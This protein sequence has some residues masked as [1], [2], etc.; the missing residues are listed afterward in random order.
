[1][2]GSINNG[3]DSEATVKKDVKIGD[4]SKIDACQGIKVVYS[5]GKNTGYAR[6]AT[7]PSAV[8]Y[9]KV[10]VK[11]GCLYARY[12]GKFDRIK[13]PSIIT[14]S[15][16][17]LTNIELS[18]AAN[19]NVI[20]DIDQNEA[21]DIDLSSAA[22]VKFLDV[23]CPRLE[24]DL[25]SSAKV[26]IVATTANL[27][28]DCSSA[29][30][31]NIGTASCEKANIDLS[32]AAN[33]SISRLAKANLDIEASSAAN[34]NVQMAECDKV[35]AEASSGAT[36][37]LYGDCRNLQ[38]ESSSGGKVSLSSSN[39]SYSASS[40]NIAK[41]E[42][43]KSKIKEKQKKMATRK[44]KKATKSKK[45]KKTETEISDD[46]HLHIP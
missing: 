11:N 17:K 38:K 31:V 20:T 44:K 23:K 29:S 24:I 25:S 32:S 1:M 27:D 5:Q 18:S 43:K 40:K 30:S 33:A 46:Y 10:F 19:V 37:K 28:I 13:G 9:L 12:E 35:Y 6:I 4:F 34:A 22:S 3:K 7:T 45:N 21:L 41:M 42:K 14:V 2:S 36:I 15:S 39:M 26:N 16:K 8:D